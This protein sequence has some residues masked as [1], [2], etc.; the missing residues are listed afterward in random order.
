MA[1]K[2][3]YKCVISSLDK[4]LMQLVED[5]HISM[6]DTMKHKI[7]MKRVYLKNLVQSLIK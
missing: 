7:L 2:A 4:D 5:P 6:M 1:K 3:K